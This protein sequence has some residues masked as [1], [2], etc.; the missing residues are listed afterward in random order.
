MTNA[1][2]RALLARGAY[3]L[4][5]TALRAAEQELARLDALALQQPDPY[6]D[7][8]L[9]EAIGR[10]AGEI[11]RFQSTLERLPAPSSTATH[12]PASEPIQARSTDAALFELLSSVRCAMP[13]GGSA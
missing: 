13:R 5:R 4:F 8:E 3:D 12:S 6:A 1:D 2:R 10:I 7:L 9:M 11:D